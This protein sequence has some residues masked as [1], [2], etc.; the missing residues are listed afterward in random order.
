M[1]F[2][3]SLAIRK[4]NDQLPEGVIAFMY[5]DD[6]IIYIRSGD[7]PM[8]TNLLQQTFNNIS[9]WLADLGL[10][11]SIR[12]TQFIVFSRLRNSCERRHYIN[13]NDQE[14]ESLEQIKYLGIILDRKLLWHPHINALFTKA[15]RALNVIRD[16]AGATCISGVFV[17]CDQKSRGRLFVMG[18]GGLNF[19]GRRAGH[20]F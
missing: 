17:N 15:N 12:K 20:I 11:I 6:I 1:P 14:M 4:I 19:I 13:L 16:L 9:T 2:L 5:V 10:E 3:F 18:G 7:I 8:A